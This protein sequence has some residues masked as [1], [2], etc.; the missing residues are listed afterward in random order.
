MAT[1]EING[2]LVDFPD[3]LTP[4]QLQ[5]AVASAAQQMG[6][7][8]PD[9]RSLMRKG[10][11]ALAVPEQKSRDGLNMLAGM[12]PK[13]EPTGNLGMDLLK[14]TPRIAA[15]TMAEAAPS[16]V[17]RG[18]LLAGGAAK[19]AGG[20]APLAKPILRAIGKQGE[21]LSGIAPKAEGALEAAYKDPTLIFA[22][23]KKA[24]GAAYEAGKA[25]LEAGANIFKGMYKPEQILDKAKDYLA[26]GG[27][28]EP[29]EAL[30]VRKAVDSLM[31]SGRYVKDELMAIR[32]VVDPMA[33]ASS[34]ISAGDVAYQRGVKAEALRNIF[35]Q[36]KYGGA[37][38]FKTALATAM[39]Q[40]G[41]VGKT[42]M[43]PLFSPITQGVVA[44]GAGVLARGATPRSMLGLAASLQPREEIN[45]FPSFQKPQLSDG[46]NEQIIN[47]PIFQKAPGN[48]NASEVPLSTDAQ[49]YKAGAEA[50]MSGDKEGARRLWEQAL[51]IN[52]KNREAAMGLMRLQRGG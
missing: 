9:E 18:A 43:A 37:S 11:D 29:A 39:A 40:M 49:V 26:K 50:Y 44:T 14:G 1:V 25:E 6:G 24:A 41:P 5:Q 21:E 52:P 4:E 20:M 34:N 8:Q 32:N 47:Q 17:S 19:L 48:L 35:P 23:G 45:K 12:V 15:E 30:I 22:K 28:F 16:F 7:Q 42:L 27:T 51:K 13:P 10:W 33:K 2:N 46:S 38:G 3:D 36:N 31:K